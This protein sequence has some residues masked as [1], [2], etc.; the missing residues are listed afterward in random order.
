MPLWRFDFNSRLSNFDR[1]FIIHG[2]VQ[3]PRVSFRNP[4]LPFTSY[5]DIF[6]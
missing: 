2:T 4:H 1:L 3:M 5:Y 6:Y